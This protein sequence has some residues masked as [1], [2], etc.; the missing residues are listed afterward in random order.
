MTEHKIHIALRQHVNYAFSF[1][2][3]YGNLSLNSHS[4][5]K[6]QQHKDISSE[7]SLG[8]PLSESVVIVWPYIE[9]N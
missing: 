5:G 7:F 3:Q 9:L 1:Q 4:K 6:Y 2:D 8:P